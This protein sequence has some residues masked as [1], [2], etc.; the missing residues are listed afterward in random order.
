[1]PRYKVGSDT[2]TIP[3]DNTEAIEVM[4]T[5]YPDASVLAD[6]PEDDTNKLDDLAKITAEIKD[7]AGEDMEMDNL[8]SPNRVKLFNELVGKYNKIRSEINFDF[9]N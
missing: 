7:I 2:Y 1:M 9:Y 8:D 5:T 6:D 4:N 3:D